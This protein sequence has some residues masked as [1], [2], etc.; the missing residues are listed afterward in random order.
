MLALL[1]T[2]EKHRRR[3]A[4]RLLVNW[5]IAKSEESGLPIYVQASEQGRRL[6]LNEGFK[7][8]ETAELEPMLY[9]LEGTEKMIEMIR[10]PRSGS[11]TKPNQ[12]S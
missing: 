3:G 9:G 4:G 7:D 6:Y 12:D 10:H 5:G 11:I 1:V 2:H 8:M